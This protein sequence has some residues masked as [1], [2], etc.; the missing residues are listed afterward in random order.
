MAKKATDTKEARR[1]RTEQALEGCTRLSQVIEA[2]RQLNGTADQEVL[3][4]KV[5]EIVM[6]TE[7]GR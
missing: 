7:K 3:R 6:A 2:V 1:Q 4:R 5:D